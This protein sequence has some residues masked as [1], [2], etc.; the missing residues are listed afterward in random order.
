MGS[1]GLQRRTG[2]KRDPP[3]YRTDLQTGRTGRIGQT[4]QTGRIG[5]TGQTGTKIPDWGEAGLQDQSNRCLLR[6]RRHGAKKRIHA[7]VRRTGEFRHHR[8]LL[9][10]RISKV[11]SIN[12]NDRMAI[13]L[14]DTAFLK[15]AFLRFCFR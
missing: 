10:E 12:E 13:M 14:V 11:V 2:V 9:V 7:D 6:S 1:R 4:G 3:C 15:A 8:H 5:Q